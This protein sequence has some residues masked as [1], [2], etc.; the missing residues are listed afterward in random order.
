MKLNGLVTDSMSFYQN[1][2]P[3]DLIDEY[4]SPLYV[5]NERIFRQSCRDMRNMCSYPKFQVNYAVK[6]NCNLKLLSIAREEGL[7]IDAD[8]IGEATIVL[9]AGYTNKELL[10][11]VNNVSKDELQFAIDNDI[12]I[13]VDS[14]SQLETYGKCNPGGRI[15]IRFN[16]GIGGG[17]HEKVVTGGDR[18]KFGINE[19][20][21]SE[22]KKLLEKYELTLVG[23]NQHIGSLLMDGALFMAGVQNLLSIARNFSNLEFINLGGGLLP[24]SSRRRFL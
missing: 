23:I 11:V 9:A 3:N 24:P 18:T 7:F 20:Y 4:G 16:P 10:F 8:S 19:A 12:L 14:L 5:Y 15:A 13:S 1:H 2:Q 22:V 6:A 21:I 17:H